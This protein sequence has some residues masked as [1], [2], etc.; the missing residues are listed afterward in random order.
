MVKNMAKFKFKTLS[1]FANY[2][3]LYQHK[4]MLYSIYTVS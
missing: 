4:T 3:L 2:I 1:Y